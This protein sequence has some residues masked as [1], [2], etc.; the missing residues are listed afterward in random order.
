MGSHQGEHQIWHS[1]TFPREIL[2]HEAQL[3][4]DEQLP[5]QHHYDFN[6]NNWHYAAGYMLLP[7][8]HTQHSYI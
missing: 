6:C 3:D 8:I 4:L 2:P 5:L 7:Y 1:H